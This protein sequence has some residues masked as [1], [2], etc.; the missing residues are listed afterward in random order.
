[1]F[2]NLKHPHRFTFMFTERTLLGLH[3]YV[4]VYIVCIYTGIYLVHTYREKYK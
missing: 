1:M 2:S 4:C 3:V